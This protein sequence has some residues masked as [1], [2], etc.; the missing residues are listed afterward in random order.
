MKIIASV[1]LLTLLVGIQPIPGAAEDEFRGIWVDA[2]HPGIK[3]HAEVTEMVNWAKANNYSALLVQVRKRGDTLYCS[4]IE[5]K[6]KD[7]AADYDPLTDV[8]EQAHAV[9]LQVHAWISVYE[10]SQDSKWYKPA[11][12]HI[13]RAHPDWLMST[14]SGL[15]SFDKGK[16]Y[17]DPGVPDAQNHIISLVREI[18]NNYAVDGVHLDNIRYP[19]LHG[20][21]NP[22]SVQIFNQQLGR[23][24]QPD[25]DDAAWCKWRRDQ[26][27]GLVNRVHEAVHVAKP[28][29][30]VSAA[31][32]LSDPDQAAGYFLQEW[33][34]WAQKGYLDFIVPMVFL[35]ND[36]MA[37]AAPTSVQASGACPVYVGVAGYLIGSTLAAK[38]ITDARQAGAKGIVLFSYAYLG[39]N[40]KD[41]KCVK[42]EDLLSSVFAQP[43]AAPLP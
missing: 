41:P 19:G 18:V 33:D 24:G 29:V 11:P 16:V 14:R 40:S 26:I 31:V 34:V 3:S 32:I 25:D 5:P 22:T 27:T 23:V 6:A 21:Y 2:F 9:G 28:D 35:R 37:L 10:V 4:T 20:G 12:N 38:Q 15:T 7:V 36:T 39:P 1:V 42:G 43:C 8:V 17:V 13:C 30:K